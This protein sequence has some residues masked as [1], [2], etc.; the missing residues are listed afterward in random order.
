MRES[1]RPLHVPRESAVA[2]VY[3]RPRT[4]GPEGRS[5]LSVSGEKKLSPN[6]S[7]LM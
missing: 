1:F 6:A 7:T 5:G 3:L 4:R 2:G